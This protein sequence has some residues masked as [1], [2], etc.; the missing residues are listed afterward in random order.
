MQLAIADVL[1]PHPL[2]NVNEQDHL[3]QKYYMT[4]SGGWSMG[5]VHNMI[6]EI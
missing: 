6:D 4:I 2:S 3:D 1:N 5:R